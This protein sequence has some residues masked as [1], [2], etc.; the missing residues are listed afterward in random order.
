MPKTQANVVPDNA[1]EI[2]EEDEEEE[3]E[4]E[5]KGEKGGNESGQE[6]NETKKFTE[7]D[8]I[9]R[10]TE[11]ISAMVVDSPENHDITTS[12]SKT[13]QKQ[14]CTVEDSRK[15]SEN[16]PSETINDEDQSC[17]N[18]ESDETL[19]TISP[20]AEKASE[21]KSKTEAQTTSTKRPRQ[22][23]L[24]VRMWRNWHPSSLAMKTEPIPGFSD[25]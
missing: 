6:V 20:K 15:N 24:K 22:R 5:K 19:V 13:S 23:K 9:R 7:T 10:N 2:E 8:P 21:G 1:E 14:L 12:E 18:D 4:E 11:N 16:S 3:E 25:T 17:K